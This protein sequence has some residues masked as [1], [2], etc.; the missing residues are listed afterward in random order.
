MSDHVSMLSF[1][2]FIAVFGAGAAASLR[3]GVDSRRLDGRPN[4]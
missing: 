1:I 3:W 4:W 2:T